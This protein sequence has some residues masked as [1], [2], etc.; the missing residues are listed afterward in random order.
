MDERIPGNPAVCGNIY[1]GYTGTSELRN[2]CCYRYI[3]GAVYE[4]DKNSK[5]NADGSDYSIHMSS[6]FPKSAKIKN[7]KS[8]NKKLLRVWLKKLPG[9]NMILL[10]YLGAGSASFSYDIVYKKKTYHYTSHVFIKK[11]KNPCK[12]FQVG[13]VNYA[14]QFNGNTLCE[15]EKESRTER[16]KITIKPQKGWELVKLIQWNPK[17]KEKEL[18]NNGMLKLNGKIQ[19]GSG[20]LA[21]LRYYFGSAFMEATF[22]NKMT[23]ETQKLNFHLSQKAHWME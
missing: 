20:F 2:L 16:Y 12:R 6:H 18:K 23:G 17:G 14:S 5:Y 8:N 11:Y 10:K 21:P 9:G 22:L 4:P 7:L 19:S 1:F 13:D 15:A 3:A